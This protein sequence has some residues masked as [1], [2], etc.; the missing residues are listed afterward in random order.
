MKAIIPIL[1]VMAV[2]LVA[3]C[4]QGPAEGP[5]TTGRLAA[6]QT[7]YIPSISYDNCLAQIRQ[8]NPSMTEQQ[9]RD[10]CLT[11]EAI[12]TGN[13]AL[14]SQVSEGF[15]QACLSQF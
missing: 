8:T 5:S 14:C 15:R 9:A 4:V 2:L 1:L 11:I 13:S 7:D 10:N 3:G 6:D 12:N